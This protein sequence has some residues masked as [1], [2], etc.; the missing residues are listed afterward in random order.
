MKVALVSFFRRNR[1]GTYPSAHSL[2]AMRLAGYLAANE[3][4]WEV[5]LLAYPDDLD[6][7][8][9]ARDILSHDV[10]VVGLPAYSWTRV[11]SQQVSSDLDCV[12]VVGGPEVHSMPL[13]EW[14]A[15]TQFVLGQGELPLA[16]LGRRILHRASLEDSPH[17]VFSGSDGERARARLRIQRS[18]SPPVGLPLYDPGFDEL[19]W[20]RPPDGSFTWF[21]TARGCIYTCSFCGHNTLPFFAAMPDEV[22]E[23]ELR[24]LN[25]KGFHETFIVD[26]I[27]GGRPARGKWVLDTI[28]R[29]APDLG[30]R[31]YLRPEF[32][33]NEFVEKLAA[34]QVR[35]LHCG[36]QTTNPNVPR[37]VRGN[38]FERIERY[39]PLLSEHGVPWRTELIVG[40]PGD[41]MD[42]LRDSIR[43]AVDTLRPTTIYAYR[44]TAIPETRIHAMLDEHEEDLWLEADRDLQVVSSSSFSP[45]EMLRMLVYA[46]AM[47]SLY[48]LRVQQNR[49]PGFRELD[50]TVSNF[51]GR[52]T[53]S[54]LLALQRQD[55]VSN[56]AMWARRTKKLAQ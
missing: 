30:I 51:L 25:T 3:T 54:E 21:E 49:A 39:L 27:L 37:H 19:F 33:D 32:L 55:M 5:G 23:T 14:P 1:Q 4:A 44:L 8:E 18:K 45:K 34:S 22:V 29:L 46:G 50:D 31:A 7:A 42:G 13:A 16:W 20:N 38:H 36:I 48:G 10:A 41:T 47:T 9:I 40:L 56:V 53:A 35:E 24:N 12:I 2:S 11:L 43:F 52:A 26:P 6:P 28:R 15:G 17:A